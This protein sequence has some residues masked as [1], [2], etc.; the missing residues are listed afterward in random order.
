MRSPGDIIGGVSLGLQTVKLILDGYAAFDQVQTTSRN[1]G[2]DAL[3]YSVM[4]G[5]LQS[6]LR[7]WR[8]YWGDRGGGFAE[9]EEKLKET[10]HWE[11]A[12]DIHTKIE[13]LIREAQTITETYAIREN[14]GPVLDR[15]TQVQQT[16]EGFE[17]AV[18]GSLSTLALQDF[19][20]DEQIQRARNLQTSRTTRQVI[21]WAIGDNNR[22]RDILNEIKDL[23][24]SLDT[25]SP[26]AARSLLRETATLEIGDLDDAELAT[27]ITSPV[28]SSYPTSL[29]AMASVRSQTISDGL[30]RFVSSFELKI[31]TQELIIVEGMSLH[32][33]PWGYI[34]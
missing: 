17:M 31:N 8:V 30:P 10:G 26:P 23:V 2:E 13:R 6:R 3:S 14:A 15:P 16:P 19:Q 4:L 1:Y 12:L 34:C 9:C 29:R 28:Q 18:Q 27:I 32:L 24:N 21:S 20:I 5:W 7:I 25:L 33:E 22:F 11:H